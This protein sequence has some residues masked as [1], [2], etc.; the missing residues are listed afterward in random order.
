[1]Q[2]T[3]FWAAGLQGVLWL[4]DPGSAAPVCER[5]LHRLRP[6]RPGQ[7]PFWRAA[8]PGA[9]P[10]Q[11]PQLLAAGTATEEEEEAIKSIPSIQ[12]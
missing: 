5:P 2:E 11:H 4:Q 10:A 3:M 1:M 7:P 6:P 8:A 9:P 12:G